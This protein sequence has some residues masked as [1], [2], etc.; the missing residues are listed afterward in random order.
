MA[1]QLLEDPS[2][3]ADTVAAALDFP[4]ASAFRN[5]CRRYLGASPSELRLRGGSRFVI[6]RL[7]ATRQRTE[8][9]SA[10]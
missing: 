7:L 10:A 1:S 6:E 3:S 8:R 2:R 5:T 4:S 9:S